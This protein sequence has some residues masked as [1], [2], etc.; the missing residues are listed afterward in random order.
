[1]EHTIK[2]KILNSIGSIYDQSRNC[3]LNRYFFDEI[4]H[5]LD[6]VSEY[7]RTTKSQSFLI[8]IVY[9]LNNKKNAVDLNDLIEYFDC[10]PTKILEYSDDL[11]YLHLSGIF[12][13][14]KSKL[15][16]NEVGANDQFIINE[17]ISK[18]ILKDEP[19]PEII[20]ARFN[21]VIE[22]LEK[23]YIIGVQRDIDQISTSELF[24]RTKELI[25]NNLHFPLIKKIDQ[26]KLHI[27]DS[28]LYLYIIWKTISG[29]ESTDIYRASEGI[30][31]NS[32]QR[33]DYIKKV[34][35]GD[36]TLIRTNLIEIVEAQLFNDTMVSLTDNSLNLLK[37]YG[38][39]PFID[40]KKKKSIISSCE[41]PFQKLFYCESE[42]KQ[43]FLLKYL[44]KGTK[45]QETQNRL[46]GENL[47]KGVTALLH[48][49]YGSDKTEIVKQ[50]AEET[51]RELM[52]VDFNQ[53]KSKRAGEIEKNI[54][55]IFT[56]YKSFAKESEQTPILFFN[57]ADVIISKHREVENSDIAQTETIKNI[58]LE[59][60][61]NFEGI[62]IASSNLEN[63][64][65]SVI[66]KC[67]LFIIQFQKG[68][69]SHIAHIMKSN[70][71]FLAKELYNLFDE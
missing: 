39:N 6:T 15:R 2:T 12:K 5:E 29:S 33:I 32:K 31:D 21:D 30:Y 8:A 55:Q 28:H 7:F 22:F 54:K 70:M 46:T 36:N 35:S 65:D 47:S 24:N 49:V 27:E 57:D 18:A 67:F 60:L 48:G 40:K 42:M 13:K 16:I 71:P 50:I 64:L 19:M 17:I 69:S 68:Y 58:F 45:F 62:L 43:L 38:I 20:E 14:Q 59:E 9:S 61:N 52:I 44:L 51:S 41:I 3:K 11:F 66:K 10:D 53:S 63:H 23:I 25:S 4:D 37:E 1:M 34:L 56:D 26:L